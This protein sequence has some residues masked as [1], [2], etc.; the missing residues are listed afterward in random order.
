MPGHIALGARGEAVAARYLRESGL[1][2]VERNWRCPLGEL[3]IIAEHRGALVFCEVKTRR[4]TDFGS[5]AEAVDDTKADR[6]RRLAARWRRD[7]GIPPRPTRFD[8]VAVL[9]PPGREPTV[10]HLVGV[11]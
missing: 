5:P 9:W 6:I 1:R 4:S 7:N 3:D 10:R 11:F 2:I 8:I